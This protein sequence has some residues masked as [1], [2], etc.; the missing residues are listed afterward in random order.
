MR[1]ATILLFIFVIQGC[2]QKGPLTLPTEAPQTLGV[3]EKQESDG[4]SDQLAK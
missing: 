2:G 3:Q 1:I 4:S